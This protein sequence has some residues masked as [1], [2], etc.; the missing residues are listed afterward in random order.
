[1][2]V[3]LALLQPRAAGAYDA[4]M[5]QLYAM[6]FHDRAASFRALRAAGGDVTRAVE[7]LARQPRR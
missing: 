3:S 1:M 5:A 7:E 2:L 6:G 4:E